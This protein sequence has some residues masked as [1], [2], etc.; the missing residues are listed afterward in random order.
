MFDRLV[1]S[2]QAILHQNVWSFSQGVIVQGLIV[3]FPTIQLS[4]FVFSSLL[5]GYSMI[6]ASALQ[7]GIDLIRDAVQVPLNQTMTN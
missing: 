7:H 5:S 6:F 1:V 3:S 2:P 4:V